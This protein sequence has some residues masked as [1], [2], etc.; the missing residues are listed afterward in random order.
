LFK[1]EVDSVEAY[2]AFDPDRRGD[3]E[4]VDKLI[5]ASGFM[6]YFHSGTPKG[7][8]GMQFKMIGYGRSVSRNGVEWP[9]I[10]VALQKNYISI[11]LAGEDIV[12]TLRAYKGLLG[13]TRMGAGNFSFVRFAQLSLEPLEALMADV[14]NQIP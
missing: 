4:S 1:V 14:A 7:Q 13:E 6:R 9:I 8:R 10:G 3:L 5:R 2:L 12:A 11:Y